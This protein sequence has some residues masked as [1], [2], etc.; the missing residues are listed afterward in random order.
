MKYY[1]GHWRNGAM[2]TVM[3]PN[4]DVAWKQLIKWADASSIQ[5][6]TQFTMIRR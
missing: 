4:G 3:A 5:N 1:T 2:H 6:P